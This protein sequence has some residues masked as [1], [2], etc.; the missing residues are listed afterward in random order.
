[1]VLVLFALFHQGMQFSMPSSL[2]LSQL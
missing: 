1:M 2:E